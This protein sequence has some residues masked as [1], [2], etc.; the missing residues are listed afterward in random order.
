MR[1]LKTLIMDMELA[2][3]L[4]Y[5]YPSKKPQYLSSRQVKERTFCPCA[6]WNWDHQVHVNKVSVLDDPKRF[7]K[8]HKDDYVVAVALHEA[9]SEADIIVAHNGDQFDIKQANTL[10]IRHNLGPIPEKKSVDTLKVARKY[11]AFEGNDLADLCKR[12]GVPDKLEKPDFIKITEGDPGEIRKAVKYCGRDTLS[13]KGVLHH[14][15]PYIRR[16]PSLR[17]YKDKITCCDACGSKRLQ[18][19]GSYFCGSLYYRVKCM[20]CGME[21]KCKGPYRA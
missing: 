15:K 18:N 17:K 4:Y 2:Y 7:K 8:N 6:T 11:F 5:A 12:F 3:A 20:E 10:F 13:L 16:Y 1:E 9:M 21:H 19:K 14:L